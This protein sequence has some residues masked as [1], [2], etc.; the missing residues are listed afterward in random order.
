MKLRV[1]CEGHFLRDY[2][3]F[4]RCDVSCVIVSLFMNS[5]LSYFLYVDS[6]RIV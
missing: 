6:D 5:I 3:F 1:N 4:S 2:H